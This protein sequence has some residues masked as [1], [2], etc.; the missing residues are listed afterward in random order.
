VARTT[1]RDYQNLYTR[2]GADALPGARVSDNIQQVQIV[3]ELSHLTPQITNRAVSDSNSVAAAGAGNFSALRITPAANTIVAIVELRERAGVSSD[4][5]L[6]AFFPLAIFFSSA[7]ASTRQLAWGGAGVDP[8]QR[9]AP[10]TTIETGQFTGGSG[11]AGEPRFL[12]IGPGEVYDA[13]PI[14][15]LPGQVF[16][17]AHLAADTAL[18]YGLTFHEMPA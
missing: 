10:S 17:L 4:F 18:L 14:L 13:A 12:Q 2:Q 9:T 7:V 8:D 6:C 5:M 3:D 1:S 15:I 16:F 11:L